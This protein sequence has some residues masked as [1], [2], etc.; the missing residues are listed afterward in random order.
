MKKFV[1]LLALVAGGII[2]AAVPAFS[3]SSGAVSATVS[4]ASTCVTVTPAT[5]SF[6]ALPFSAPGGD[7]SWAR[8]SITATNCSSGNES[9]F[10]K[11]SN[12]QGSTSTWS[13]NQQSD[14][15]L[16][17]NP[18]SL[19]PGT[20]QYQAGLGATTMFPDF[21]FVGT[22]DVPM[23]GTWATATANEVKNGS[24]E[25]VMPCQGSSGA[26]ETMAFTLTIIA[27]S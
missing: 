11:G 2:A 16:V 8:Q 12:A 23:N 13:L 21:T 10:A 19:T 17:P 1:V 15:H 3:G 6:G 14:T 27:V 26:G 24:A 9:Y 22:T 5:V 7:S 4:V 20:N 25:V 18:C